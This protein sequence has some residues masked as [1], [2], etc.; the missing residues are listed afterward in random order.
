MKTNIC[1][2]K[3]DAEIKFTCN[4]TEAALVMRALFVLQ[5][6][7]DALTLTEDTILENMISSV[8]KIVVG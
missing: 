6:T 1:S 4:Q 7:P 3:G 2:Q 8:Y 5:S